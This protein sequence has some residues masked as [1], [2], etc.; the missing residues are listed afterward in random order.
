MDIETIDA[1]LHPVRAWKEGIRLFPAIK[2]GDD[3][4][5]G[6]FLSGDQVRAF[7]EGHLREMIEWRK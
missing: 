3:V 6:F 4:L 5:S 1:V 7:V 2:I